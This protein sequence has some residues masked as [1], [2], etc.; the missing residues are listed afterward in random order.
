MNKNFTQFIE[1]ALSEKRW[2]VVS[3]TLVLWGVFYMILS[4]CFILIVSKLFNLDNIRDG[5]FTTP[6]EVYILL[7]T[8]LIWLTVFLILVK[9]FHKRGIISLIGKPKINF[10]KNFSYA[11]IIAGIFLFSTQSLIPNNENILE[12]L[13]YTRWLKVLPLGI[14]LMF[15]QVT[16]EEVLFRGYLQQQLAVWENMFLKGINA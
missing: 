13:T 7:S 2:W 16:A 4:S 3:L 5:L 9:L 8:F 10:F 14:F 15:F 11:I 12:N 1:P 6:L